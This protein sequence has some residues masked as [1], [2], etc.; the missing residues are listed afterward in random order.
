MILLQNIV[1]G[2]LMGGLYGLAGVGFSL[3]WGVM[4]LINLAHGAF[5]MVGAYVAFVLFDA[6]HID[7]FV[8]ILPAM[9]VLFVAGYVLQRWLIQPIIR[10]G[11]LF[12]LMLTFGVDLVLT[13]LAQWLF[14]ANFRTITTSYS[15]AGIGL[16]PVVI[17]NTRLAAGVL[18]VVLAVALHY[19]LRYTRTGRAIQ[20]TAQNSEAAQ[21][22]GVP[23]KS[24]YAL[25]FGIGV[26]LAGGA[27]AM[28]GSLQTIYP[29]M[30]ASFLTKAF[31]VTVMG[32]LGHVTGAVASG[33]IL[34]LAESLGAAFIGPGYSEAIGFLL[35]I[36]VLIVRPSGFFGKPAS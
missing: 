5:V 20:A 26:A 7:P 14:T 10:S 31:V 9:A 30:G 22:T 4:G 8:G 13:N 35:L 34:G 15:G 11:L 21:L 25:T 19:F 2:L 23:V 32:G 18:A 24:I 28:V 3:V 36:L 17:P 16:G 29:F 1:N 12:V 33:L 27:G 6:W